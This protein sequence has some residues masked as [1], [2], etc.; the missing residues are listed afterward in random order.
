[1]IVVPLSPRS[2]ETLWKRPGETRRNPNLPKT[3]DQGSVAATCSQ[4][5]RSVPPVTPEV[6]GSSPVAPVKIPANWHGVL[7][8]QTPAWGRLHRLLLPNG[9]NRRDRV[10]FSAWGEVVPRRRAVSGRRKRAGGPLRPRAVRTRRRHPVRHVPRERV[11]GGDEARPRLVAGAPPGAARVRRSLNRRN[12][13][14]AAVAIGA[15]AARRRR[16]TCRRDACPSMYD[17]GRE[18]AGVV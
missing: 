7:S 18:L 8:A 13:Q 12:A 6:A 9:S 1:V 16:C 10:R 14:A 4:M 11:G 17:A 3:L 2:L 15:E 5:K